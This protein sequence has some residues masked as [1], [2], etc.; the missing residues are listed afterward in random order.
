[1]KN[2]R[3]LAIVTALVGWMPVLVVY[4]AMKWSVAADP[5]DP[6]EA[7]VFVLLYFTL[8]GFGAFAF[9]RWFE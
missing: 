2:V 8:V 5:T 3:T 9:H 7:L 6:P 1:M 4:L